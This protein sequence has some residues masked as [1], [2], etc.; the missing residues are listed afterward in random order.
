MNNKYSRIRI[1]DSSANS[2][3][4]QVKL[5]SKSFDKTSEVNSVPTNNRTRQKETHSI[6]HS[7]KTKKA[8]GYNSSILISTNSR[9]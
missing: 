2:L 5:Y 4:E 9:H 7:N 3:K 8:R 6:Q 1:L